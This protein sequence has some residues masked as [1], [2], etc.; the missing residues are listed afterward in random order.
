MTIKTESSSYSELL[1][2]SIRKNQIYLWTI[3]FVFFS[4]VGLFGLLTIIHVDVVELGFLAEV[5]AA[6]GARLAET[7]YMPGVY[8]QTLLIS[9]GAAGCLHSIVS[10]SR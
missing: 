6:Q 4:T 10:E 1:V 7:A 5:E 8:F 9:A 2:E 3:G